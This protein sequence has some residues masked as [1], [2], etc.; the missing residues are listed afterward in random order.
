M[1]PAGFTQTGILAGSFIFDEKSRE[2]KCFDITDYS[3]EDL[4]ILA[5][6]L[7]EK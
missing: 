7:L 3:M 5:A 4:N 1:T 6:T 2:S